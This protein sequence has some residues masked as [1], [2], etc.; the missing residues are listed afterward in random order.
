MSKSRNYNR[1]DF[2]THEEE[3]RHN[4]NEIKK[5]QNRRKEKRLTSALKSKDLRVLTQID[6]DYQ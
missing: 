2:E 3:A 6:D 1:R 5:M 4:R